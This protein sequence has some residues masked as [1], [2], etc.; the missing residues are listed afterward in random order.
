M[1]KV[2]VAKEYDYDHDL[3]LG[4]YDT[5]EQAKNAC[6]Q[7]AKESEFAYGEYGVIEIPMNRPATEEEVYYNNNRKFTEVKV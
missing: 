7:Y 1:N 5:F 6:K 3:I 2:Y 4:V